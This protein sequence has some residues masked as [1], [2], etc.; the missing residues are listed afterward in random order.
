MAMFNVTPEDMMV[1]KA[2]DPGWYPVEI[3]EVKDS[4][5][6]KDNSQLTT[7]I[8]KIIGAREAGVKLYLRFSE[9]APG[10]VVPF[11]E[12]LSGQK[13]DAAGGKVELN[14]SLVGRQLEVCVQRG[15]YNGKPTNEVAAYAPMGTNVK[16]A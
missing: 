15:E 2:V 6:K 5:A 16:A 9:K 11:V 7:V 3:S 1:G 14:S 13:F 12:A 8:C 4:F 10:F